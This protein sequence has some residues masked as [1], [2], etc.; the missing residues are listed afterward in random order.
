LFSAVACQFLEQSIVLKNILI[1]HPG[2]L[3]NHS[4]TLYFCKLLKYK[5]NVHYIGIDEGAGY[6]EEERINIFHLRPTKNKF[7]RKYKYFKCVLEKLKTNKFSF[8]LLNYFPLCSLF[9]IFNRNINVEV[10][11]GY[12]FKSKLKRIIFNHFLKIEVSLFKNIIT[13]S[14][15]LKNNLKLPQR[16]KIIPLGGPQQPANNLDF[17]T[18]SFLYVGTFRQ[19]NLHVTIEAFNIFLNNI[20][21]FQSQYHIVGFGSHEEVELIKKIIKTYKLENSVFFHGEV[22]YPELFKLFSLCNV[23]ISYVPNT[24]YFRF[25]PSTKTLEYLL[26]GMPVIATDIVDH[27]NIINTSN[28]VIIND[29]VNSIAYGFK[30]IYQNKNKFNSLYIQENSNI[31]SW[32][33]I[34]EEILIPIITQQIDIND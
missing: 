7:V 29:D 30:Y 3:G 24:E 14:F 8:V 32:E 34:V 2:P 1:I 15:D 28:G 13:L 26:N 18:L 17:N 5:Y 16:T 19:R 27:K 6:L 9:L 4:A 10:R 21:D 12:I 23:G 33:Y 25:Q 31:Y 11:S 20:H 22:R